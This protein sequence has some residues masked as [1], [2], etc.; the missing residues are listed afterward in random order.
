MLHRMIKQKINSFILKASGFTLLL[1]KQ[2]HCIHE[3][4]VGGGCSYPLFF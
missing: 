4:A 2:I 1:K 3:I